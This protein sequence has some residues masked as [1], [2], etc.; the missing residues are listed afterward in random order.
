MLYFNLIPRPC[1][2]TRPHINTYNLQ[3]PALPTQLNHGASSLFIKVTKTQ[4]TI[5]PR[6]WSVHRAGI[7][8]LNL[9]FWNESEN[10]WVDI[11]VRQADSRLKFIA[12]LQPAVITAAAAVY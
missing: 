10:G 8:A 3:E 4:R 12:R 2:D 7:T 6:Q 5:T 9:L 1:I 11:P